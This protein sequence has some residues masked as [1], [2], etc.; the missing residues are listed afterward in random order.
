[1]TVFCVLPRDNW[2]LSTIATRAQLVS[3]FILSFC[4]FPLFNWDCD[5]RDIEEFGIKTYPVHT[6]WQFHFLRI[7]CMQCALFNKLSCKRFFFLHLV[8]TFISRKTNTCVIHSITRTFIVSHSHL[9]QRQQCN[10]CVELKVFAISLWVKLVSL[11][12]QS[13]QNVH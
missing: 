5:R 8:T 11:S 4:F 10:H 13:H 3:D 12:K 7:S 9:S 6:M 1:M 2:S